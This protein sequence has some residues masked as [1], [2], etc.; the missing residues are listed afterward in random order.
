MSENVD[1]EQL[2][3]SWDHLMILITQSLSTVDDVM[4]TSSFSMS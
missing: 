3:A 4:M 1:D 2:D